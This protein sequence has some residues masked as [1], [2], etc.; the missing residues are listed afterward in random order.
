MGVWQ[1]RRPG[2]QQRYKPPALAQVGRRGLISSNADSPFD[3]FRIV[4]PGARL[5]AGAAFGALGGK[6]GA[7]RK[8]YQMP[9]PG[10]KKEAALSDDFFPQCHGLPRE[11]APE[12]ATPASPHHSS[13]APVFCQGSSFRGSYP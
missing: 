11:Q 13:T 10:A 1:V 4:K 6:K 8:G 5:A 2:L 3:N 9:A 7:V 12:G